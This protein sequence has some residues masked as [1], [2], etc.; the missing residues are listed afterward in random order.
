M[1]SLNYWSSGYPNASAS[2]CVSVVTGSRHNSG[3]KNGNCLKNPMRCVCK[4]A[5]CETA[6]FCPTLEN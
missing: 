5:V 2:D 1:A 6:N 3:L 4:V